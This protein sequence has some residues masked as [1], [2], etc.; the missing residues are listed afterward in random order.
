M[1]QHFEIDRIIEYGDMDFPDT[2]KVVNPAWRQLSKQRNCLEGKLKNRRARFGQMS[3]HPESENNTKKYAKWLEKKSRLLEEIE[4]FERELAHLKKELKETD[5]HICWKQLEKQDKFTRLLP[6]RKRL[7]DTVRMIAYRAETA[8]VP[9]LTG[10]TVD[11]PAARRILQ[12]FIHNRSGHFACSGGKSVAHPCTQRIAA[13]NKSSAAQT[14][15]KSERSRCRI[16]G[17]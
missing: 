17:N 15:A 16:S 6:N 3:M 4:H 5:K 14:L 1:M 11:S 10:P 8:M 2:E 12:D 7:M 9:L 13:G